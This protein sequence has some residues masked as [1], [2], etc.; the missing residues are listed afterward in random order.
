M[1]QKKLWQYKIFVDVQIQRASFQKFTNKT[2]KWENSNN[3]AE[4]IDV[5]C[6]RKRWLLC[7]I[8][9]KKYVAQMSNGEQ[10]KL[11]E[12]WFFVLFLSY[13]FVCLRL[14][15]SINDKIAKIFTNQKKT[16][17]RNESNKNQDFHQKK[18]I[19]GMGNISV[20]K[21]FFYTKFE[22]IQTTN[23]LTINSA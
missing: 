4:M 1:K 7:R 2:A 11:L 22:V 16:K 15:I 5:K 13:F 3:I 12:H 9:E 19:Y 18:I 10:I 17:T 21:K 20:K 8:L 23:F 14:C 6:D